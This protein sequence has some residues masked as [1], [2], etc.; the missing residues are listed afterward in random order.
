MG[1]AF[2]QFVAALPYSRGGNP[3]PMHSFRRLA[4]VLALVTPAIPALFAQGT[5]AQSSGSSSSS[6]QQAPSPAE[7]RAQQQLSAAGNQQQDQSSVQARI[8]AR[9]E[10]RRSAAIHDAYDHLY[11]ANLGMAFNRFVPGP[12]RQR[13]NMYAWEVELTR[14]RNERLGYT[15]DGRGYYGTAYVGLNQY[16]LTRPAI[17]HYDALIGPT[18][19]FF[20]LPKYSVS[21]RV[22][23]GFARSNFT[24]DTNGLGSIPATPPA[25]GYL[26][27]Q[28]GT[29]FAASAAV[30]G[31]YNVTPNV[32]VRLAPEYYLTGFGSTLQASRGFIFGFTYRFGRQ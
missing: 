8:R 30:I 4:L 24:G 32:G 17:S 20:I 13:A 12:N 31:E 15:L 28:D 22:M 26:L 29:T 5:P 10:Q 19:R 23:G 25:T 7:T 9:R 1:E 14:F 16:N 6:D 3:I 18:Y 27:Y 11:E 21:G 2:F